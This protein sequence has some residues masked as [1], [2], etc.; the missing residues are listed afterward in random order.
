MSRMTKEELREDP[1]LE[2]IQMM[3]DYTGR[4]S[5]WIMLAA[6]GVVV[7]VVAVMMVGRAQ[8]QAEFEASSLLTIGQSLFLQGNY[9]EAEAKLREVIDTHGGRSAA[10]DA[11]IYLGDATLAQGRNEE[12]LQVYTDAVGSVGG[13]ALEASARRGRAAAL[14]SLQ[15]F[16]EA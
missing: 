15:R 12:A 13:G 7:V 9:P 14:E 10:D 4:N 1:V 5:R 8:R 2:R 16:A 6:V 3:L 11:R